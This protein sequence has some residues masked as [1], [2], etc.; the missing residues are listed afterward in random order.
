M[1]RTVS[2][3]GVLVL[4]VGLVAA[5]VSLL[6]VT[7]A[8]ASSPK[9]RVRGYVAAGGQHPPLKVS[10][11]TE[12]WQYL[13]SR[14]VSRSGGYGLVLRPGTYRLQFS[15]KR[16]SYDVTKLAATDTTVT[17]RAGSTTVRNARMTR[18]AAITG[19]VS[20]AGGRSG[21]RATV[22]A[23]SPDRRSFTTVANAQGE[24][25]LG[26]LPAGS[27]SVF[28]YDHGK[29]Y[30]AKSTYIKKLEAG[31]PQN[32][33]LRLNKKA[34]DLVVDLY[35]GREAIDKTLVV[36]AVSKKTGQFWTV[37][38]KHG[39]VVLH[40]VFPGRYQLVV[41]GYGE[42]LGRT[43]NVSRGEVRPGRPAFGS[44]RLTKRGGAFT[45]RL[46]AGDDHSPVAKATVRIYDANGG[47]VAETTTTAN[48]AFRVGGRL[49][50]MKAATL[51]AF[52]GTDAQF[53]D[54][55]RVPKLS[56]T[57]NHTKQLGDLTLPAK[58]S[59]T[60][61]GVLVDGANPAIPLT[62]A[63][64]Q[65][66]DAR[67]E[68]IG[69][70]TSDAEG[71]FTI[72]ERLLSQSNVTATLTPAGTTSRVFYD[73]TAY[74]CQY[75]PTTTRSITLVAPDTQDLGPVRIPRK[76]GGVCTAPLGAA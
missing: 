56:V 28:T 63:T 42:Y 11:F 35:A 38:A 51:V 39:T 53:F 5:L 1:S 72:A 75:L 61:T 17:V 4:L 57:V 21:S 13:G 30:V 52:G 44:F 6:P 10:W 12:D 25:A 68:V 55:L 46:L 27:Y 54:T 3:A 37:K 2:R 67:G 33:R 9:G 19:K 62:G 76:S 20:V 43:G 45:G 29:K 69:T 15:D 48:G 60:V 26:G 74:S 34:G 16:P 66:R 18:G 71:S 7:S 24:F 70:A 32:L 59:A 36:T 58:P 22:V 47:I 50:T 65:L 31:R 14:S 49:D 23:A 64:V 41:P 40:G 8:E 73:G